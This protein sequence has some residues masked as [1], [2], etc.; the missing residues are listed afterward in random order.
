[1]RGGLL[2]ALALAGLFVLEAPVLAQDK[3]RSLKLPPMPQ[4]TQEVAQVQPVASPA[5]AMPGTASKAEYDA[6]FQQTMEHPA[7][8]DVLLTL[9]PT[10][11]QRQLESGG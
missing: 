7:D 8:L 3:P 9:P 6:A 5:T 4:A 2:A 10:F 1:M 11:I